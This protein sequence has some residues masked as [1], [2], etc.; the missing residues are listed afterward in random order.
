MNTANTALHY[1]IIDRR[2]RSPVA[3]WLS[4]FRELLRVIRMPVK[5]EA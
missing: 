2:D 5:I 1:L 4:I 3:Y